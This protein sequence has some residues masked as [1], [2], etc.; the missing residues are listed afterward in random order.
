M[1]V[2]RTDGPA[3]KEFAGESEDFGRT[4]KEFAGESAD[5]G[6]AK[7]EKRRPCRPA[8]RD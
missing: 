2:V 1:N 7:K 8:G 3:A 5:F 4:G 6:R